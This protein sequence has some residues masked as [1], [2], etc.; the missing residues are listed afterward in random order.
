MPSRD[1]VLPVDLDRAWAARNV[2]MREVRL[3]LTSRMPMEG[4]KLAP[5]AGIEVVKIVRDA[6]VN[7][8]RV[9]S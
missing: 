3:I 9:L 2:E 7:A 6:N 1:V 5:V 8:A 4:N